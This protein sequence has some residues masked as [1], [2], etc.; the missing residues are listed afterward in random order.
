ME[1]IDSLAKAIN[2]FTGGVVLVSHDMRLI[3]QVAKEI[4]MCDN[5]TVMRYQGEIADFKMQI[6][7]QLEQDSLIE[8]GTTKKKSFST[9]TGPLLVPL[10]APRKYGSEPSQTFTVA[11]PAP[12]TAKDFPALGRPKTAEEEIL[13]A[14][15]ELAEL[16][17]Q[18]QRDRQNKEKSAAKELTAEEES[19]VK[20]LE[21]KQAR[22]KEERQSAEEE[23]R[24]EAKARKKAE[25][26][27]AAAYK[28]EQD[29]QVEA[30]RQEKLADMAAAR[31]M[32]EDMEIARNERF[33][34]REEKAE[35]ER[36]AEAARLAE[37]Q[38]VKDAKR[39]ERQ[40]VKREKEEAK[41]RVLQ[42]AKE[43]WMS[44]ARQDVWTQEQQSALE[45]GLL[46][47]PLILE[48][49]GAET[50]AAEKRARWDSVAACVPGKHRNQ[51][52]LRYRL[53]VQEVTDRRAQQLKA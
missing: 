22:E 33:R 53:L 12:P 24:A 9:A 47:A 28:A 8:A 15:M 2:N 25:K 1:S 50:M 21:A 20:E 39:A 49:R 19:A 26:E 18:R 40:R 32:Q 13:A 6:Q 31:K 27:K 5:K 41:Q 48:S 10:G 46:E 42:A 17:I 7:Q 3:S 29:A 34:L 43:A 35:R 44:E 16:A 38:A 11:P 52:L 51:C 30:R 4:W 23:A 45:R 36:K 14:R 37:E